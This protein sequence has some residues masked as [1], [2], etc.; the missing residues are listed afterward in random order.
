MQ[1]IKIRFTKGLQ[2]DAYQEV[3]DNDVV[4]RYCDLDGNTLTPPSITE[5]YVLNAAPLRP[6][7]GL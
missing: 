4:V 1:Y 2:Q 6:A 3:D 5:S 7:W